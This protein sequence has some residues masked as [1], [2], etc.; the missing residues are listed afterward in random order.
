MGFVISVYQLTETVRNTAK[1]TKSSCRCSPSKRRPML[2]RDG[3]YQGSLCHF[4]LPLLNRNPA[5]RHLAVAGTGAR[6]S[7]RSTGGIAPGRTA[8]EQQ[9]SKCCF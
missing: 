9:K 6:A 1:L 3:V 4:T 2:N 8:A 5:L 7:G